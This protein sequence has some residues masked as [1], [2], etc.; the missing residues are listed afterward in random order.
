MRH[1]G[2][3]KGAPLIAS[4]AQVEGIAFGPDGH[5]LFVA[6]GRGD[7]EA[8]HVWDLRTNQLTETLMAEGYT[9]RKVAVSPDGKIIAGGAYYS[10]AGPG[11]V[12]WKRK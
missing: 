1:T 5:T 6:T 10:E 8:I 9:V 7:G 12:L 11:V 4:T 3:S 2:Q